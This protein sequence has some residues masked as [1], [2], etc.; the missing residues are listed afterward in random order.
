LLTL[1]SDRYLSLILGVP[2]GGGS[3][4]PFDDTARW[5]STEDIYTKNLCVIAGLILE[6]NQAE[7]TH[8]FSAT[9]EIDEKL[10]QLARQMPSSW[11][12]LPNA[13]F[14]GKTEQAAEHFDKVLAHLWHFELESLV[15]LPFMLRAATDRRYEYSRITCLSASRGLI[16]RWLYL[17]NCGFTITCRLIEFQAFTAC[18]TLLLAILQPSRSI[19]DP[20]QLQQEE[21]DRNLVNESIHTLEQ[22]TTRYNGDIVI[23]QSIEVLRTLQSLNLNDGGGKSSNLRLTIPHF[24]TISV[25]KGIGVSDVDDSAKAG[26]RTGEPVSFQD[27]NFNLS[28]VQPWQQQQEVM[29]PPAPYPT[30]PVLSFT[31]SQFPPSTADNSGDWVF[32]DA[33]VMLFDS[34]FETD[35]EGHWNV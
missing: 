16:K 26:R 24:G 35:V 10:D 1:S 18:V 23:A 7:V 20:E 6:R 5:L 22:L 11:W 19:K 27:N 8:A 9:Q 34:L 31:S 4:F 30:P 17:Q 21:A 29:P 2:Q 14:K 25:T 33:N 28:S 12:E 3:T 15:H 13:S 32:Q